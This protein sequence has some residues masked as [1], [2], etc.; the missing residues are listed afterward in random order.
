MAEARIG[1]SGWHYA[2]WGAGVFYPE[3]LKKGEWLAHFATLFDTVE[4]NSSFYHLPK[5]QTFRKWSETAPGGFT[6]AV[7][8]S[9]YITHINRLK[10][11]NE[12]ICRFLERA[13]LLG[14]KLGPVLFQLPPSMKCDL[15]RL[16]RTLDYLDRQKEIRPIRA[17]FEFRHASWFCD[18]VRRLLEERK[19]AL[20]LGDLE[21]C[22][23]GEPTDSDFVYVRRHG[24]SGRYRGCYSE[25]QLR[26]DAKRT[27]NWLGEGRDV[28]VYFN[29]DVEGHAVRNALGL[30]ELVTK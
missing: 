10:D 15:G 29:N 22:P 28:Y 6:F 11:P 16:E 4:I 20:C 25:D 17:A 3:G 13:R 23:V 8:A 30:K 27:K 1:T 12:A 7:K 19:A 9:R 24:P 18:D 21:G 5:E 2:H 14:E 26:E